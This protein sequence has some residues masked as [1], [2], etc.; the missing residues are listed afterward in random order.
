MHMKVECYPKLRSTCE[1]RA[2]ALNKCDQAAHAI[3]FKTKIRPLLS[4]LLSQNT[5]M[6]LKPK[7]KKTLHAHEHKGT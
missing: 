5:L 4:F 6:E 7:R 3:N 1:M 2:N